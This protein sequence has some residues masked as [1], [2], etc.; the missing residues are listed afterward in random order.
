MG[1]SFRPQTSRGPGASSECLLEAPFEAYADSPDIRPE[2]DPL[3][4][5]AVPRDRVGPS[6]WRRLTAWNRFTRSANAHALPLLSE[7]PHRRK[8]SRCWGCFSRGLLI[9]FV[10]L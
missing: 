10:M 2:D 9:F 1:T 8:Y 4:D 5:D 6:T 3:M 7:E